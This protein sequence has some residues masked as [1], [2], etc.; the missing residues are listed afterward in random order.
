MLN[1]SKNYATDDQTVKALREDLEKAIA[2][3]DANYVTDEQVT[4]AKGDWRQ[5]FRCRGFWR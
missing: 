3:R 1:L 4:F 5:G 2:Q